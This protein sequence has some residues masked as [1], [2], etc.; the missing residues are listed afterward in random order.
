[1]LDAGCAENKEIDEHIKNISHIESKIICKLINS[2]H[3][4]GRTYSCVRR[5]PDKYIKNKQICNL[6]DEIRY[7]CGYKKIEY[8]RKHFA[9]LHSEE[10][11][12]KRVNGGN[13][14]VSGGFAEILDLGNA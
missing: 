12:Y 2:P 4:L 9:K 10:F 1:M 8:A 11:I 13:A 3:Y 6:I 14:S 7:G 5:D